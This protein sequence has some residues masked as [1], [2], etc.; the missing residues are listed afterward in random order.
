MA[1]KSYLLTKDKTYCSGC[2][3]CADVCP[4]QAVLMQED[5]KGFL[6]PV[7]D[8]SKCTHCNLCVKFC[9][10]ETDVLQTKEQEYYAAWSSSEQTHITSAS[11]GA[12][13]EIAQHIVENGGVCIG[14]VYDQDFS[15][16]HGV[17]DSCEDLQKLKTSKYSQSR[18]EEAYAK[19]KD[20][21]ETGRTVCF[22]GTPCQVAGLNMFLR[23][24]YN[25]LLTCDLICGG[26]PS[27]MIY[28]DFLEDLRKEY[29]SEITYVNMKDKRNGWHKPTLVVKFASGKEYVRLFYGTAFG[30]LFLKQVTTRESC[31]HCRYASL[32]RCAD[33]TI[34]D[35]WG[36]EKHRPELSTE[37]GVSLVIVN[38]KQGESFFHALKKKTVTAVL[39]REEILQSRLCVC[40]TELDIKK[41][42]K[43][44]RR[45]SRRGNLEAIYAHIYGPK[46]HSIRK[47]Y[48]RCL[49]KFRQCCHRKY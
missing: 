29:A 7:I 30:Q 44:W 31:N 3:T 32:N 27:P 1:G 49:N 37:D 15:V 47:F 23:K 45:Y 17:I 33:I 13:A 41:Y 14:A 19:A 4:H 16:I 12:G 22:F 38:T 25:N 48:G 34:G 8:Q 24:R 36:V 35:F 5:K 40:H 21:L 2:G 26:V 43:F 20:L 9:Q 18:L 46:K 42:K 6:Y 28:R 10:Y 39:Q 11:G